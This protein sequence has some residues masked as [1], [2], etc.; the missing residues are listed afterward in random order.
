MS[1]H[2][3]TLELPFSRRIVQV[4]RSALLAALRLLR[5]L[6]WGLAQVALAIGDA[7]R[8]TYIDPYQPPKNRHRP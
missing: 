6:G 2:I 1:D 3:Q 8:Q 5:A 7:T 4:A